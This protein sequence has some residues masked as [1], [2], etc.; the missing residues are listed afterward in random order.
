MVSKIQRSHQGKCSQDQLSH[1]G[2]SLGQ[3]GQ[4]NMVS[5]AKLFLQRVRQP[6]ANTVERYFFKQI[7]IR[8]LFPNSA[9]C[10][11][12]HGSHESCQRESKVHW[13]EM[14]GYLTAILLNHQL[15]SIL[16][17]WRPKKPS[18]RDTVC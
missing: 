1:S 8:V 16:T 4:N 2:G 7:S 17:T 5:L 11:R 12:Q 3:V 9:G 18:Y 10:L 15:P 13:S 6:Q 14:L